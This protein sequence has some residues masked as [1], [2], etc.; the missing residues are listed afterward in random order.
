[1]KKYL[2]IMQQSPYQS[3]LAL[4]AL[5]FALAL[6]AFNQDVTLL[7]VEQGI[8]QLLPQQHAELIS[9]KNYTKAYEGLS[10]FDINAV[11]ISKDS[12]HD[13]KYEVQDLLIRPQVVDA[14]GIKTLMDTHDIVLTL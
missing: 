9:Y 4:E 8:L 10:L 11:Y 3:S 12:L 14:L 7:F 13:Y 6:G 5:E 2:L 1:M